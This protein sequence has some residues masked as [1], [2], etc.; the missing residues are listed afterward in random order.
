M[1]ALLFAV[2]LGSIPEDECSFGRGEQ[3]LGAC[4]FELEA[5][6]SVERAPSLGH[7]DAVPRSCAREPRASHTGRGAGSAHVARASRADAAAA[8][9]LA[10][11]HVRAVE[12]SEASAAALI[13]RDS[14]DRDRRQPAG[15]TSSA[16]A[17]AQSVASARA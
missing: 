17:G 7:L 5:E 12:H 2:E 15:A 4:V 14:R 11:G 10:L 6:A 3:A 9:E 1:F 13:G 16:R 8:A